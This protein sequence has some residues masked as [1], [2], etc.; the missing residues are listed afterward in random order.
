[1][2][3]DFNLQPSIRGIY[4]WTAEHAGDFLLFVEGLKDCYKFIYLPSS[5]YYYLSLEDY[6]K[7]VKSGLLEFVEQLPAEIYAETVSYS[8]K[9]NKQHSSTL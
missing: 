1:M 6:T 2:E 8:N 7:A 5:D 9:H 4:A 3:K